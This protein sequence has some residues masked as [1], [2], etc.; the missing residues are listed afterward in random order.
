MHGR[1]RTS[2]VLVLLLVAGSCGGSD[3]GEPSTAGNKS[4]TGTQAASESGSYVDIPRT[5]LALE[6]PEGFK[7]DER[8]PGL[9]RPGTLSAFLVIQSAAKAENPETVLDG[10]EAGFKDEARTARQ[11]VKIEKTERF[12]VEGHPAVAATGS[13]TAR[14][15]EFA[16]AVVA[17]PVDG[18]LVIA[19]A[20]LEADDPVSAQDAL[21]VLRR[22]R[23]SEQSAGGSASLTITPAKGYEEKQTSAGLLYTLDG[24]TGAGVPTFT[25]IPSFSGGETPK[26]QRRDS[27]RGRFEQLPGNPSVETER[28]ITIDGVSGSELTG[29]GSENGR[30]R[31]YY[32]VI[33][34]TQDGYVIAVGTFD[35]AAHPDQ[36]KAF[37]RMARSLKLN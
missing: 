1:R 26:S 13:Q 35:P 9:S 5:N 17:F 23:W 12:E 36:R 22:A 32:T 10:L 8:L 2:T 21:D 20:T 31:E 30:A 6:P 15:T 16:K 27:A 29:S 37:E 19:T 34:F 7:V 14:G 25:V 4:R 18:N 3:D 24:R 33:L 28:S 11:G